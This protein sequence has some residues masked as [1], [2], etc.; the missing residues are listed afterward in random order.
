MFI[1]TR[2]RDLCRLARDESDVVPKRCLRTDLSMYLRCGAATSQHPEFVQSPPSA[3]PSLVVPRGTCKVRSP[4]TCRRSSSPRSTKCLQ[5]QPR[6]LSAPR[7]PVHDS[8]SKLEAG[9]QT[10]PCSQRTWSIPSNPAAPKPARPHFDEP[11]E[12]CRTHFCPY[13]N[14]PLNTLHSQTPV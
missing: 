6:H 7:T 2:G 13:T 11:E 4:A 3:V 10:G 8:R 9:N 14:E 5:A 1:S 12:A